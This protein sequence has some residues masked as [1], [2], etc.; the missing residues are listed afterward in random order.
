MHMTWANQ[1]M[2]RC[3]CTEKNVWNF[4]YQN[5]HDWQKLWIISLFLVQ[6]HLLFFYHKHLPFIQQIQ[7]LTIYQATTFSLTLAI[8]SIAIKLANYLA[9]F[10][11]SNLKQQI[12]L[13]FFFFFF[14]LG[15]YLTSI[16]QAV[17][18]CSF[19][20]LVSATRIT[21]NL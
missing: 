5:E 15:S 9:A 17:F 1:C 4:V 2:Q 18:H 3:I 12:L 6:L 11:I 14:P 19:F 10:Y 21:D 8:V 7:H 20:F 13:Y 16:F